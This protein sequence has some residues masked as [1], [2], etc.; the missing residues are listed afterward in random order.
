MTITKLEIENIRGI[1]SKSFELNII[2]NK[3]SILVAPNGFGK[4]SIAT[5]FSRLNQNRIAL[6][7]E[8]YHAG[9]DTLLPQI[10]LEFA[11]DNGSHQLEAD[12]N[13]NSISNHFSWYV[14]NSGLRAK[15]I[16]RNFGGRINVQAS[17][18]IEPIVL[19]NTIP[20]RINSPYKYTEMKT[21]FGDNGKVLQNV[22]NY[23]KA[24]TFLRQLRKDN[25]ALLD[26]A[27]RVNVTTLI[28]RVK[29]K[30]NQQ[31][32]TA[33]QLRNWLTNN[34]LT[35]LEENPALKR[36]AD[37]IADSNVNEA[38]RTLEFLG[39]IQLLQVYKNDKSLFKKFCKYAEYESDRKHYDELLQALNT[40]WCSI[41]PKQSGGKLIV[42]FPN[43][44]QI[45]N[46]QR[47]LIT[48]VAQLLE[49]E[50]KLKKDNSILIIDEVFDY[51]DDAN[52]VA[53]QYF[54]TQFIK[55]FKSSGKRI[56]PLILT[57][58]NPYYFKNFAFSNQKV[59]FLDKSPIQPNQ[60]MVS[61]LRK[62]NDETIKND[63]SKYLLHFHTGQI[64]ARAEFR[65]LNL[66]ESWGEGDNFT[67]FVREQTEKYLNAEDDYDPFAVCCYVRR[68]IEKYVYNQLA[69]AQHKQE[70]LDLH[71]TR[72]KLERAQE[73]GID[74]PEHFY[75]LGIIYNDGMHWREDQDNVSPVAAKLANSTIENLIR[76][77]KNKCDAA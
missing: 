60:S 62:R 29:D 67:Q 37:F 41:R 45:S 48:F 57:H 22:S 14:I 52:L 61:L 27:D 3:P 30:I 28:Q 77:V 44:N 26:Q 70:F 58:L 43:A 72:K 35:E 23:F 71:M 19:V 18:T 13:T 49:A 7:D 76:E 34:L 12:A 54:I 75:L 33:D 10:A 32:E 1:G 69:N 31:D 15:G 9:D 16:G 8:D 36:I 47:D 64:N 50:R 5:A 55:R 6:E 68:C 63:V 56:Y 38:N 40:S 73:I 39:A 17:I 2:P 25:F 66:K 11:D 65:N 21:E 20:E 46:G 59:Y 4:S 74:V 42:D 24:Q 53:A 51:L